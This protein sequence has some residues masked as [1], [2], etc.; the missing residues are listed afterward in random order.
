MNNSPSIPPTRNHEDVL[1][2]ML[3]ADNCIK[4]TNLMKINAITHK[5][6]TDLRMAN[7]SNDR[8]LSE[9]YVYTDHT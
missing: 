9:N 4:K 6:E 8:R 3:E 1:T 5:I 2:K 7:L